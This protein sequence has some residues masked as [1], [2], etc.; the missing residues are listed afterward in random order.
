MPT[1]HSTVTLFALCLL[2]ACSSEKP[3]AAAENLA[4]PPAYGSPAAADDADTEARV[5]VESLVA[6]WARQDDWLVS[7]LLAVP[8]GATRVGALLDLVQ[9]GD[10]PDIHA[11][12][13]KDGAVAS[14]WIPLTTTFSEGALRVGISDFGQTGDAA[15]L[16]LDV[17]AVDRLKKIQW[18]ATVPENL[19]GDGTGGFGQKQG[20]LSAGLDGLGMV[21]RASWK[22]RATKCTSTTK[23][24]YRMAIHHTETTSDNPA[25]RVRAIQAYHMDSRGWCDIGYHFLVATDGQIF[26]GRP[27]ALVG[28]HVGSQNSGNI[29]ISHIGCF[30]SSGCGAMPP[31]EPPQVMLQATAKLLGTLSKLENIALSAATVKGHKDHPGASTSCPGALL[32]AR[33]PELI[34]TG[35]AD[36]LD[37]KPVAVPEPAK[38]VE[39]ALG[40]CSEQA[41]GTCAPSAGCQWCASQGKCNG[42]AAACAWPGQVLGQNCWPALWPCAVSSCWNPKAELANCGTVALEEDFSSGKFNVH[43]YWV[44]L[45]AGGPITVRLERTA[46]VWA[47][48]LL[49]SDQ[50]GAVIAAGDGVSLHPDVA[51]LSAI[52]G[53]TGTLAQVQVQATKDINAFVY[54]ASWGVL[55]SGFAAKLPTTATYQLS[56]AQ[57]CGTA[58]APPPPATS[59]QTLYAGLSQQGAEIPRA[60][61]ANPTLKTAF[62]LAAEPYGTTVTYNG[63]TWVQGKVSEFGGPNDTGVTPTETG[64]ITGENLRGLNNPLNPSAAVLQAKPQSYY[65]LAMRWSYTPAAKTWWAQ[66]RIVAVNPK[67]GATVVLRPVDWGPNPSTK[68]TTDL[69]PQAR[70]DLGLQTDE[71]ALIAFAKPGAAVGKV[72]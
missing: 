15:R 24:R 12:I 18:T 53:K 40:T 51:V 42:S 7:P 23:S 16:R 10:I 72:K 3:P 47:P 54:V 2:G 45:P 49:I 48:A 4:L 61:L 69:S 66:A 71:L 65:Y 32:W 58:T 67:T 14:A 27:Y 33:I 70:K 1:R 59:P 57:L 60:G 8:G 38:P 20:N 5:A 63:Q 39:P 9:G 68:R 43:R 11:Q 13:F 22:A 28:A 36:S 30:H 50:A 31:A 35:K 26:E 41:C 56:L 21:T 19:S 34:A 55:D 29:G 46:G 37:G 64:A 52:V 62:S 17:G 25:Q 6:D 44:S